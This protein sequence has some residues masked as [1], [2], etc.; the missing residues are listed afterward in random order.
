MVDRQR[1]M[2]RPRRRPQ[3]PRGKARRRSSLAWTL[4][5]VSWEVANRLEVI[6]SRES[7]ESLSV[8]VEFEAPAGDEERR[9]F[10]IGATFGSGVADYHSF[11]PATSCPINPLSTPFVPS[12]V[13]H[14]RLPALFALDLIAFLNGTDTTLSP[15]SWIQAKDASINGSRRM[16]TS[17]LRW[18]ERS[19]ESISLGVLLPILGGKWRGRDDEGRAIARVTTENLWR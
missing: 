11:F 2:R 10:R 3:R 16:T 4:S 7:G 15:T 17:R 1:R 19:C 18:Q 13:D 8:C 6:R 5:A 12:S 14:V 9:P